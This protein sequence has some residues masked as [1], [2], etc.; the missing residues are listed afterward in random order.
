M[1]EWAK[2]WAEKLGGVTELHDIGEQ[3][4][5]NGKKIP[6][7][8]IVTAE[9]RTSLA[10]R[11]TVCIYG[12]LDVQPAAKE[13]GWDSE[14]FVLEERDGKLWG[15][16]STDDKGPVLG[17]L[18]VIEAYKNAN[19]PLPCNI[20]LC[21]ENMEESGSEGLEEF[22]YAQAKNGFLSDV[23][24]ICIS[25]NYWLGTEKPCVTYGLRGIAYFFVEISGPS[26]D[27]HSGVFGGVVA[28]PMVELSHLFASLV[29]GKGNI[30]VKG[31]NDSVAAVS[32]EEMASYEPIDF[33]VE[34]FRKDVGSKALLHES[35]EK[36]LMHRW[37]FPS[38]SIHGV[39]GAFSG[40]GGKTVIP[41][42]VIGKFSIRLVPDQDPD[43]ITSIVTDHLEAKFKV[44]NCYSASYR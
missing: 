33:S 7:P 26:K 1:A 13:D 37:R 11:P 4:L 32:D 23:D 40:E 30:L 8:P 28:E 36:V 25:D 17:W 12:H 29:D 10:G 42:K 41:R 14:P 2:E 38:L 35:K 18:W 43:Q 19:K 44:C 9:F 20:K 3:E 21:L 24:Y 16:G 39:E 6:L 15:R 34:A 22:V 31:V 27:L 5:P